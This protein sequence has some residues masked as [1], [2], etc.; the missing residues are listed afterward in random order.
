M[1]FQY[2]ESQNIKC[3]PD[4][5]KVLRISR[6]HQQNFE[7]KINLGLTFIY[8]VLIYEFHEIAFFLKCPNLYL[9]K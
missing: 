9:E 5:L 4:L 8:L 1:G 6:I 2:K 3:H 7:S